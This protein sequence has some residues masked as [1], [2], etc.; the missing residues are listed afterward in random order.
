MTRIQ[1]HWI[2]ESVIPVELRFILIYKLMSKTYEVPMILFSKIFKHMY[3]N[4]CLR[5]YSFQY[6]SST[7]NKEILVFLT[8]LLY[9]SIHS[10]VTLKKLLN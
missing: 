5:N 6:S 10:T 8:N 3:I 9:P 4:I 2:N 1:T 7:I